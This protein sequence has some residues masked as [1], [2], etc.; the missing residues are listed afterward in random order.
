MPKPT[1]STESETSRDAARIRDEIL[2]ETG[3]EISTTITAEEILRPA[4]DSAEDE[5][6]VDP[7]DADPSRVIPSAEVA[8][9]FSGSVNHDSVD[10]KA[11]TKR[12]F[13][14]I[15]KRQADAAEEATEKS[16]PHR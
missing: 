4:L 13:A 9:T 11:F 1:D 2:R 8:M 5:P 12:R 16:E 10:L 15:A 14:E 7:G 6:P 3:T